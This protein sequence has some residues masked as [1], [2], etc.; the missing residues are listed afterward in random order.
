MD[1][2]TVEA[3]SDIVSDIVDRKLGK[4]YIDDPYYDEPRRIRDRPYRE[5][6]MYDHRRERPRNRNTIFSDSGD[7][8]GEPIYNAISGG[9][10][11]NP[12]NDNGGVNND[13]TTKRNS[14]IKK[15]VD[16]DNLEPIPGYEFPPILF[17]GERLK[18]VKEGLGYKYIIVNDKEDKE[19]EL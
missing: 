11:S 18:K 9:K 15:D 8:W 12:F 17:K 7:V 1:R 2:R 19:W 6:A 13:T 16:L 14:S 5:D 4:G 10:K 3:I